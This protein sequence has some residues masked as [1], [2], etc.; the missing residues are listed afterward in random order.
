MDI[1]QLKIFTSVYK[2]KSFSKASGDIY[3]SQP[4]ISEH[5]KN[6]EYE[7][8]C[9]LFDRLSRTVIPTKEADLLFLRATEILE[10]VERLK[11]ELFS[12]KG[13]IKGSLILGA[14]TIP[15]TYILPAVAS[16][17]KK[18]NPNVSFQIII[19]DS[20]KITDMIVNHELILG[21]VG[22]KMEMVRINYLPIVEDELIF[23]SS[24]RLL[25][26]RQ[27]NIRDLPKIPFILREEGSGTKKTMEEFLKRDGVD[28]KE[29][30]IVA[31]LGSTDSVKQAL[32]TGLGASI[33]SRFAVQDELK[34]GVLAEI[35]IK[36]LKMVRNFYLVK[37]EKRT[38]PAQYNAFHEFLKLQLT[39]SIVTN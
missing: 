30:N 34:R 38:L 28:I 19:E 31:I 22:A 15:G 16:E 11:E 25:K 10:S 29:L 3:L 36:G 6:L 12:V 14:S 20:R 18:N 9:K 1:H 2:N 39:K 33:L 21:V 23:V 37:H 24:K 4:T 35:K 13:E 27:I 5:I 17:F 26:K 32:R 8:S 7:L